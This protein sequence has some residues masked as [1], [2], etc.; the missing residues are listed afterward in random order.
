MHTRSNAIC[1][2]NISLLTATFNNNV[3]SYLFIINI[4]KSLTGYRTLVYC[5]GPIDA[6]FLMTRSQYRRADLEHV[7]PQFLFVTIFG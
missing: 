3:S 4:M 5:Y 1:Y 6:I 7:L 2:I